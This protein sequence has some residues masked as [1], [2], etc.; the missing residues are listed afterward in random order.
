MEMIN[1]G[2]INSLLIKALDSLWEIGRGRG[3]RE[4]V[5]C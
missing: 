3:N 2:F 1:R 5:R 4:Y